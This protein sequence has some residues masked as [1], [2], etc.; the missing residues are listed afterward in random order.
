M[1]FDPSAFSQPKAQ[2]SP[3]KSR[4]PGQIRKWTNLSEIFPRIEDLNSC[5]LMYFNDAL[6]YVRSWLNKKFV[7]FSSFQLTLITYQSSASSPGLFPQKMGGAGMREKPWGRGWSDFISSFFLSFFLFSVILH[8]HWNQTFFVSHIMWLMVIFILRGFL[9]SHSYF[10]AL[11]RGNCLNLQSLLETSL[12][13]WRGEL[14]FNFRLNEELKGFLAK[15][16]LEKP[17]FAL[18]LIYIYTW[19]EG[20]ILER[21]WIIL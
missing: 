6:I 1:F 2:A 20:Q 15:N 18:F 12:W 8:F 14:L 21:S 17:S 19:I 5:L 4:Y 13:K 11:L 3:R 9:I 10:F 7:C 16:V